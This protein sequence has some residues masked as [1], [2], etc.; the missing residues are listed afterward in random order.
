MTLKEKENAEREK[1]MNEKLEIQ[2]KR[3]KERKK[4]VE[5]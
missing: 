2:S 3:E 4:E 5:A 1:Y